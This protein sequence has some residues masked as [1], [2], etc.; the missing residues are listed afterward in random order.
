MLASKLD[1]DHA[2]SVLASVSAGG[3]D[4]REDPSLLSYSHL[5]WRFVSECDAMIV[6]CFSAF[7]RLPLGDRDAVRAAL[8]GW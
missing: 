6:D 1:T 4:S 8:Y 2:S 7:F 3:D 5:P